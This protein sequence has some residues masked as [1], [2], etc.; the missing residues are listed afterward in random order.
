MGGERSAVEAR[1]DEAIEHVRWAGWSPEDLVQVVSRQSGPD[2]VPILCAA[3]RSHERRGGARGGPPG[4]AEGLAALPESERGRREPP[5]HRA[6]LSLAAFLRA[7]PVVPATTAPV[8]APS[9]GVHKHLARVRALLAKA[10]STTFEEEADALTTKAQELISKH[11][12]AELLDAAGRTAGAGYGDGIGP[13]R[14]WLDPPY[15]SAKVS[16]IDAVAVANRCRCVFSP[17]FGFVTLVGTPADIEA[18]DLLATS[19]L[20]Q[21]E[22]TMRRQPGTRARDGSSTT[23]SYRRAFLLSF[24]QRIRQRL[25]ETAE[26]AVE[27]SADRDLLLPVI[28]AQAVRVEARMAELFPTLIRSRD[29]QVTN[30]AGWAAGRA[31]ADRARLHDRRPVQH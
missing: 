7:L 14:V 29:T 11:S 25:A 16:L 26:T 3:L 15:V 10:E 17:S 22:S 12:L 9:E 13:R 1:M 5:A 6:L 24:G 28:A 20:A 30:L 18:V 27:D 21:A 4:W 8:P 23:K 31:A 19:L 2:A